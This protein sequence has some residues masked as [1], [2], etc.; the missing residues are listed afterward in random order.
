MTAA[1]GLGRRSV[2]QKSALQMHDLDGALC[3]PAQLIWRGHVH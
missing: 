2:M 1:R 3:W